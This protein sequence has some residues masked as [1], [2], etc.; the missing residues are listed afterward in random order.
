MI[1]SD[2]IARYK[3]LADDVDD[4]ISF[5]YEIYNRLVD[6][7]FELDNDISFISTSVPSGIAQDVENEYIRVASVKIN[8]DKILETAVRGLQQ[9]IINNYGDVNVFL[10]SNS[11][12]VGEYFAVVSG[13]VGYI[14]DPGNIG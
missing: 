9:Y 6:M 12:K 10:S 14:I 3:I 8:K 2:S 11:L 7:T 1:N 4:S 5:E 13:N